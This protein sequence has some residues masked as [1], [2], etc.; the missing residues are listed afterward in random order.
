MTDIAKLV[1]RVGADIKDAQKGLA[2]IE[3]DLGKAESGWNKMGVAAGA[4]VAAIAAVGA[5]A[6]AVG[7]VSYDIGTSYETAFAGVRK[8]VDATDEEFK[9]ISQSIRGMA[10]EIP[11]SR[12]AISG[13]A[14]AAGQLGIKKEHLMSFSRTM[15]DLGNSTN[16]SA[17]QAAMS[18]ARL[19]NIT[20]M[21]QTE[22]DR[23][24]S[25][26]V[27]LG[28]NFATTEAEIV[29][30]G[31]RIAAAGHQIGLTEA[32]I[33]SMATALSSVG[34]EAEAGGT[35]I[36]R[37]MI[38]I[39][40]SVAIGDEK[41]RGFAQVAGMTATEFS[42]LF[43]RDAAT[44]IAA[45]VEGL[46][47]M[48][49]SGENVFAV[50]ED[51]GLSEVRVRNAL[52]S[53][54]GA[55]D[56]FREA[57]ELGSRAWE[58]NTALTKE[59]EER[60]KT[61]ASKVQ[62]LQNSLSDLGVTLFEALQ[63]SIN[64]N[65]DSL[66]KMAKQA[67]E[68]LPAAIAVAQ[69]IV[70]DF[71]KA[72]D[73][74]T[75]QDI[76]FGISASDISE[77]ILPT[78][79]TA[80]TTAE[81]LWRDFVNAVDEA[82]GGILN[83]AGTAARAIGDFLGLAGSLLQAAKA[84]DVLNTIMRT[85][86][87]TSA[88]SQ[89]VW[90]TLESAW[91]EA[92]AKQ[93]LL[94]AEMNDTSDGGAGAANRLAIAW[95]EPLSVF[96]KY[97]ETFQRI[98]AEQAAYQKAAAIAA[99]ADRNDAEEGARIRK[100]IAGEQKAQEQ[101]KQQEYQKT[102]DAGKG[103]ADKI[104]KAFEQAEKDSQSAL[105]AI[106]DE[107]GALDIKIMQLNQDFGDRWIEQWFKVDESIRRT[108]ESAEQA[109]EDLRNQEILAESIAARKSALDERL[110]AIEKAYRQETED[111][112]N[113]YNYE[114]SIERA[115]EDAEREMRKARDEAEKAAI[116]E[117]LKER[118][119][120]MEIAHKRAM[121]DLAQ[122]RQWEEADARWREENI[123]KPRAELERQLHEEEMNRK[124]AAIIEE[125][126]SK[127][128]AIN[129]EW[130][131]WQ[132]VEREKTDKAIEEA[133][134][135]AAGELLA[136]KENYFDKLAE[137]AAPGL[138]ALRQQIDNS[139]GSAIARVMGGGGDGGGGGSSDPNAGRWENGQY[140][141]PRHQPGGDIFEE[142]K[143]NEPEQYAAWL[144]EHPEHRAGGGPVY[145]GMPYVVG[146]RGPE[147]FVPRQSG[148]VI[149]NDNIKP[150]ISANITIINE[151]PVSPSAVRRQTETMLRSLAMEYGL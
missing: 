54:A 149:S 22:F 89:A 34:I 58:E 70:N 141:D 9:Q 130:I 63:P 6:I 97:A 4:S 87:G 148:R 77:N 82:D 92:E 136:I 69:E 122:R 43:K 2:Q 56:L 10:K 140:I 36:S 129:E 31:M 8:T 109:L 150:N 133:K 59:A 20:Q 29:S 67:G 131:E 38:D 68:D 142:W 7:K 76:L 57:M 116:Q 90:H 52:L 42:E 143:R 74:A 88:V 45:F 126:D 51:L 11:A 1:V 144:E 3:R 33:L 24:G 102:G 72:V 23:L 101:E 105:R 138:D 104:A 40:N 95:R 81:I 13:V 145:A 35:A 96:D 85:L 86:P 125:R 12:E 151:G 79:G 47:R 120:T 17:D 44:A 15:I 80:V 5:A 119:E 50:L 147:L 98:K 132:R 123:I 65:I 124:R 25:T 49:D 14:E 146:E 55:G 117:R 60:Y 32:Q 106:K 53:A 28:N 114:K 99:A 94:L 83:A 108:I 118:L 127:I 30:M 64:D 66:T 139:I 26:V 62:V 113:L 71:R 111:A 112:R 135:K 16:L 48:K 110:A 137:S 100:Q 103:A 121:E 27:A 78:L 18:L 134:L 73:E 84:A 41:L 46:G 128:R 61:T 37:V 39:A 91:A 107:V 115:K 19:A 75:N 21:P 93:R